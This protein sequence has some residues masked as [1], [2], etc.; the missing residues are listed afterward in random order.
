[1]RHALELADCS[2]MNPPKDRGYVAYW[3]VFLMGAGVLAPWNAFIT[4]V[5]YFGAVYPGGH[6]D[7]KFSIAYLPA[8]LATLIVMVMWPTITSTIVR[9]RVG[10][11]GFTLVLLLIPVMD[12]A[13]VR[14]VDAPPYAEGITIAGLV[15]VG[16]FDG[17]CQ[18]GMLGEAAYLP[19]MYQ[20]AYTSGT[21]ASGLLISFLRIITKLALPNTNKGLRVS[22]AIYFLSSAMVCFACL[23]IFSRVLPSLPIVKYYKEKA[24]QVE[25][26][27]GENGASA[28][29]DDVGLV[30]KARKGT[31]A[32]EVAGKLVHP[33]ITLVLIYFVTLTIFPGV[34]AEDVHSEAL[35]DWYNI[36]LIAI[37]N[38]ADFIGKYMPLHT[39]TIQKGAP[40]TAAAAT[41][42]LFFPCFLLAMKFWPNPVLF[43]FMVFALGL[44]NGFLTTNTFMMGPT[45]LSGNEYD[46]GGNIMILALV[47]GLVTGAIGGWGILALE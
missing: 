19:K 20:Q 21:A 27:G 44:S 10:L 43:F 45:F 41:R 7:R 1:M 24:G 5:D 16:I 35:G 9:V 2:T 37:F 13:L 47:T 29:A 31:A 42:V 30:S 23:V 18:G 3:S 28:E 6:M 34:P 12:G 22:T 40:L 26:D 17:F 33:I 46:M 32:V 15:L 11:V 36:L 4:A 39:P 8:M 14:G 38:V 25:Q